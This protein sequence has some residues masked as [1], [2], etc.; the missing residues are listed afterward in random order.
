[1]NPEFL[2]KLVAAWTYEL[3]RSVSIKLAKLEYKTVDPSDEQCTEQF[4]R[5]LPALFELIDRTQVP[6]QP[7]GEDDA[8]LLVKALSEMIREPAQESAVVAFLVVDEP[9]PPDYN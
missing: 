1:M 3:L 8:E 5:I 2:T 4:G 6:I 7:P 9:P